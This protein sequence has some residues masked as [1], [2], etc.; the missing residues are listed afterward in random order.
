MTQQDLESSH[1]DAGLSLTEPQPRRG[2][3]LTISLEPVSSSVPARIAGSIGGV[4]HVLLRDSDIETGPGP[5]VKP[6]SS[7]MPEPAERPDKYQLFGEISRGGMGAILRGRDVD[8]GRDLAVKVLLEVHKDKPDL[9]KRFVEEAQIGGQ[10]QHPGV[11]PVYELG[12]FADQRP[13]FTMKLVKG[14]TLGELLLNR[15]P[16]AAD[17]PRFLSI[18][19]SV[20]QTVAYAHARGVIHR[21]LKPSNVMVGSFGEVQVMDWGLAKV[22]SQDGVGSDQPEPQTQAALPV[23]VIRTARSGSDADASQVGSVLGTPAYMAPEQARGELD[24]VDERADVFGLGAIL[25]EILTGQPPFT[26]SSAGETLRKAG[27]GEVGEAFGRLDGSGAEPELIAL[28]KESL[29]PERDDRPRCAGIVAERITAYLAG[30]QERLRQTEL[31]R[32]EAHA[33][34]EEERKRRKLTLGLAAA[35]LGLLTVGGSGAAVYLQQRQAQ[36]ARLELAL[37]E[38]NLLRDQAQADPVGDLVKWHLALEAVKRAEDL[39]GPLIGRESQRRVQEL[40]NHVAAAAEAAERDAGLLR[41]TVDIRSAE[42]DD[43][44]GSASDAAYA[45]AFRDAGIDI[46]ALGADAAVAQ[47][48]ARPAA[49]VQALAAALDDWAGQRRRARPRHADGWK[50]LVATASRADPDETRTRLRRLWSATDQKAQREPLLNLAKEADERS[51]P[52]ASLLLLAGALVDASERNAAVDLLRRAQA[53]HPGDVWVNYMLAQQLEQLRPPQ[54]DEAIRFYSVARAL[55]PETAHELAHAL[56][57]RGRGDEAVVVFRD[58]TGLRRENGRHWRCL[59]NLLTERRDQAASHAALG[60]AIAALREEIRLKPDLA[61]ARSNLGL[62][63]HDQ[64]KLAEAITQFREAIRLHP[65]DAWSRSYLGGV[66]REQG[67]LAEAMAELREAIRL[68]PDLAD[69][70][71][72]L[73]GTLY[74]QGKVA[75]AIV[76]FHDAVQLK[77]EDAD[78]HSNLGGALIG[79][80]KLSDA[81]AELREAIRLNPDFAAAHAN[82]GI[83][84]RL[85]GK[86]PE[87]IASCREAIRLRPD[88][89]QAHTNLGAALR[90]QGKPEEAITAYRAAIRLKPDAAV[91]HYNLGVALRDLGKASEAIAEL[92]M[93]IRLQPGYAEAHSDLGS[94]LSDRG[95]VDEAITEYREAIRLKPDYAIAHSNLGL[96]LQSQGRLTEAIA[97]IREAIRLK[98]DHADAHCI[99][100]HALQRLGEYRDA[101]AALRRG[102]ELG[103]K[104]PNWHYP[105]DQWV[106]QAER[107]VALERRLPAVLRGEDQPRNAAERMDFGNVAYGQKRYG[108]S[109]RFWSEALQAEPKL[110]DDMRAGHRYNAACVATLAA[111]GKGA[112]KPPLDE[113]ARVRWRK[114]ALNWLRADLAFSAKQAQSGNPAANAAI[115]QT[116]QHW[117]TDTDLAGI[118]DPGDLAKLSQSEQREWRSFWADVEALL[119]QAQG[120]IP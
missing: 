68:K 78:Y 74:D 49:V 106:R 40:G 38:V 114:Q 90:D 79:Q 71:S 50:R 69:A 107:F 16:Q 91:D 15:G 64:G 34:A 35:V 102:H 97:A 53:E 29:A 28:A 118:R 9:V 18:F 20:A 120:R 119:K 101:L 70:H 104:R 83:A 95:Q 116:L 96:A 2:T 52:P 94:A 1:A 88:D 55:R 59:G 3:E 92:L 37:R 22:L 8:L 13:F 39:L 27:R 25:C 45:K 67:K 73:G 110:A 5:I 17:Q 81:M 6:S 56:K 65:Q 31:A 66:L 87:A 98:P 33:R 84:L 30:V 51:L 93:A 105:S 24:V 109:A 113:P 72:N 26:G 58:L 23:S 89:P 42:A 86:L 44:D 76:E 19:E 11:V 80:A 14:R 36:T 7:E 115:T 63:L 41:E 21:D 32:V 60:K 100:G 43:P 85:E 108:V 48:N 46:D 117:K 12:S 103:S 61:A 99:L 54:T 47:I 75:E 82:L 10:L 77:P 57:S 62:V 111:A 4:P 112:D